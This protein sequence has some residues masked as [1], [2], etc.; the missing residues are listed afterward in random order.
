MKRGG[1]RARRGNTK[2][3]MG[4]LLYPRKTALE[5]KEIVAWSGAKSIVRMYHEDFSTQ[6]KNESAY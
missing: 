4:L 3:H 2:L 5:K 6:I 1:G